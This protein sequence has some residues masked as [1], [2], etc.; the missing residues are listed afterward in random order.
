MNLA[1]E[2]ILA[3]LNEAEKTTA[4]LILDKAEK[5]LFSQNYVI[6]DFLDPAGLDI[7]M[8]VLQQT[9][10]VSY[11]LAGGYPLAE[12]KKVIIIPVYYLMD[13]KDEGISVL[14]ISGNAKF[15]QAT[16]RDYLGSILGLGIKR[17]KIGDILVLDHSCQVIVSS[18]IK[19]YILVNLDKV[20]KAGVKVR[21][22]DPEQLR[23]KA[24]KVKEI[25]TTVPSLRLDAV[26]SSGFGISRSRMAKEITAELVKVNWKVI[27]NA[28]YQ[29]KPED[30]IS[31]RGKGRVMIE[32]IKGATKKGRIALVLKRYM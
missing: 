4:A 7:A 30:I 2:Q 17:E 8:K 5:A 20:G 23:F 24:E 27:T 26:A 12:R 22:I 10:E 13:I 14:E 28:S 25:K 29:V 3:A 9:E 1:R 19:D 15:F 31:V 16:H 6:T 18:D 11:L 32:E 21:E